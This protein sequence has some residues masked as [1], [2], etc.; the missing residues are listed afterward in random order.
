MTVQQ[1]PAKKG[2]STSWRK[3]VR[4]KMAADTDLM[5]LTVLQLRRCA[6]ERHISGR[7]K[8]KY[9]REL[10][11]ALLGMLTYEEFASIKGIVLPPTTIISPSKVDDRVAKSKKAGRKKKKTKKKKKS[12]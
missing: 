10:V 1:N 9:K 6:T 11:N 2:K 7:S 8:L 3:A 4:L 12:K 5:T